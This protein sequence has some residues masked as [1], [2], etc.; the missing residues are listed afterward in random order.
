MTAAPRLSVM[1]P[2]WNP[3]VVYLEQA[4]RSVLGQ[5]DGDAE[6][7]IVDDCSSDFDPHAFLRRAGLANVAVHRDAVH[8]GLAGTW[9]E[10]V[11]RARGQ[12]V[13]LLHQDDFVMPGF[14]GALRAGMDDSRIGAAFCASR[15]VDAD[16]L[17]WI[18]AVS[19]VKPGVLDDWIRHLFEQLS[20]QCCAIVVRRDVYESVGG[21]DPAFRYALDWDM[22][23]RIAVRFPIWFHPEPLACYRMH[24]ASE[25][26]RQRADGTHL[27]EIFRSI[28]R[29]AA[30]LPPDI[31]DAVT[32]RARSHYAVFAAESALS[33][34][35]AGGSWRDAARQLRIARNAA[36]A[37]DVV[38]GIA[39][40]AARSAK[41]V[42]TRAQRVPAT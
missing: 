12:W 38:A 18:P 29:S 17:G 9:N 33:V 34:L 30:L 19:D 8:R 3:D 41:R 15:F 26:A 23:K 42:L 31:T 32:R 24:S 10:C 2:T 28:D 13:H 25:T 7:A 40:V 1:V 6:V 4:L 21:F 22:W 16:G 20:V 5:L 36:S 37:A 39:W 11:A 27:E 14:Y 35:R